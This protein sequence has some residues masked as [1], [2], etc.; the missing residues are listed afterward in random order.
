MESAYRLE[1][2]IA[3]PQHRQLHRTGLG[4][5]GL[6]AVAIAGIPAI[7][8]CQVVPGIAEMVI[9]R[10]IILT[11]VTTYWLTGTA[12]SAARICR[13]SGA[14]WGSKP[15][16]SGVPT[17]VANFQGDRAV[18]GL[19]ELANTVVRWNEYPVGGH[20]ASLQAPTELIADIR[21]FFRSIAK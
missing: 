10:D 16:P 4:E 13:E 5:H 14:S 6:G 2:G 1:T 19:A 8:A 17:A 12:G 3:V 15:V 20:F 21:E 18:R 11:N 7:A 9:D